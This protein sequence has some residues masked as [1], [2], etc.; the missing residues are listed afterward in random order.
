LLQIKN[1]EYRIEHSPENK[2]NGI[3]ES[4]LGKYRI[5]HSPEN[6]LNGS[7]ENIFIIE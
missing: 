3:T 4:I 2:L 6:K 5:E 1:I 7:M